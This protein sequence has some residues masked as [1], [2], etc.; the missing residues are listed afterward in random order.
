[1]ETSRFRLKRQELFRKYITLWLGRG[2]FVTLVARP[3]RWTHPA[4][5]RPAFRSDKL[6][7]I[8]FLSRVPIGWIAKEGITRAFSSE[9]DAGSR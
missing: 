3:G 8:A 6:R 5:S 4:K 1:M 7:F 2:G 9:V